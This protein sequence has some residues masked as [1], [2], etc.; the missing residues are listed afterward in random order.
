MSRQEIVS[1]TDSKWVAKL[2][3]SHTLAE[4]EPGYNA[5]PTAEAL[6]EYFRKNFR[7]LSKEQALGFLEAL[8]DA[9]GI[10]QSLDTQFWV[11]ESLEEAVRGEIEEMTKEEFETTFTAFASQY[12]GSRDFRDSIEQR[13][14][15]A[16]VSFPSWKYQ[17][18]K[19]ARTAS[20]VLRNSQD[21]ASFMNEVRAA[22]QHDPENLKQ[23]EK[24][25]ADID[26]GKLDV[27]HLL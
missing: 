2:L 16:T 17:Q 10:S 26:S 15:R 27:S 5:Q 20:E 9:D 22:N 21:D 8:Q 24:T 19:P 18:P 12:K 3:H 7:K 23:L 4:L 6:N 14:T 13:N 11:W 25:F 1:S